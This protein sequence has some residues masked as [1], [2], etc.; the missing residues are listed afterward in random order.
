MC[1]CVFSVSA[2]HYLI[3]A[4]PGIFETGVGR[5]VAAVTLR[6]RDSPDSPPMTPPTG[7]QSIIRLFGLSATVSLVTGVSQ[8]E[9]RWLL[10]WVILH[11]RH[12][13]TSGSKL[14]KILSS[15][16]NRGCKQSL[17]FVDICIHHLGGH[18]AV[19][20]G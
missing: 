14:I 3:Q 10:T 12:S 9:F 13:L 20:G 5:H 6:R 15:S 2:C 8:P 16:L 17:H 11:S 18:L 1:V 4:Y 19:V 7:S